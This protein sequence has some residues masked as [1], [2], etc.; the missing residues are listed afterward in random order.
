MTATERTKILELLK[1]GTITV[2]EAEKLLTAVDAP[3]AAQESVTLK[4][5]RGRKSKKLRILVDA[6]EHGGD[7]ENS[8]SNAKVNV[9]IPLSLI[10]ALGPIATKSI[11]RDTMAELKNDGVDIDEI[12]R[13]V[14][15]LSESGLDEDMI[16]IDVNGG[17]SEK[18]KV[19]I[20]VE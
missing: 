8:R 5:S 12:I 16:N 9:S 14:V 15:E 20:Y 10:K 19:R 18:A 11:P 1:N 2:E 7:G 4:D 3:E 17:E 13:Q 6:I